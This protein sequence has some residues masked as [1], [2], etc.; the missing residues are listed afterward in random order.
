MI[1]TFLHKITNTSNHEICQ[2]FV[3]NRL[4]EL[5]LQYEQCTNELNRHM[6]FYPSSLFKDIS[7]DIIDQ[8]LQQF[9]Q[10]Q[11][12]YFEQKI[13]TRLISYKNSLHEQELYR[14]L[15]NFNLTLDQV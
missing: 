2:T 6:S 4:N 5:H 14:T 1:Q 13:N 12:K 3:E 15:S 8:Q 10:I 9:V 11:R 7:L